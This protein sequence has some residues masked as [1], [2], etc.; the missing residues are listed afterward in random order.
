MTI[1]TAFKIATTLR[2]WLYKNLIIGFSQNFFEMMPYLKMLHILEYDIEFFGL[3][4]DFYYSL[5]TT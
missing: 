1:C 2:S 4:P 3:K 5:S